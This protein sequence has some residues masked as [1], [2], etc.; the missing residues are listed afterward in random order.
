MVLLVVGALA[1]VAL[2]LVARD[3]SDDADPRPTAPPPSPSSAD[4]PLPTLRASPRPSTIHSVSV[5]F[6]IVTDPSTDWSAVNARLDQVR[7]NT[8]DLAAGRV[9]F[10]AFDWP[11]YPDAAAES[12]T[13]HLATAAGQLNRQADG[14]LRQVN[15]IMDA[16]IPEWIKQDPSIAGVDA[17]GVRATYTASAAQLDHGEVG[18]RLIA[19]AVALGERYDPAQV[20]VTELFLDRYTFGADD[21]ELFRSMT[22]ASDWPRTGDGEIDTEAAVIGTWR[23]E[24][25][26]GLMGR[27]RDA[28]DQVRDG[29]GRDIGLVLDVRVDWDDPGASRPLSGHDYTILLQQRISLQ[30]WVYIGRAQ[31]RAAEVEDLTAGLRDAGFDMSRFIV[32]AG[33]WRGD[34]TLDE[35]DRISAA[36]LAVVAAGA[37]T[38]GITAVNVTPYSL[39]SDDLWT[40]LSRVW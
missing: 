25:L 8:V 16:Y 33:L 22:G 36:E 27:M 34:I 39:M 15:L 29:A 13:D 26:A 4:A 28:L 6:G 12:G 21:L 40:A 38:N 11:A 30:L 24:V 35:P 23:S 18:D 3:G 37:G 5:D 31:R 14:G 7:A 19:Y 2:P 32:S 1:A 10:T 17:R 20:Q 9:E